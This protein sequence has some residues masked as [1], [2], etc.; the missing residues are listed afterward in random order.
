MEA[1]VPQDRI[2]RSA[3]TAQ[4]RGDFAMVSRKS[5]EMHDQL[6]TARLQLKKYEPAPWFTT[7]RVVNTE[8][9][10]PSEWWSKQFQTQAS[11]YGTPFI[12]LVESLGDGLKGYNPLA[13]NTDFFAAALGGDE[14]MGHKVVYIESECQ[15]YFYDCRDRIYKPTSEAKLGNLI[16]AL[17]IRCAEELPNTC[18]KLNLFL[19]FRSDKTIRDIIHR[20]KSIVTAD[21]NFFSSESNHERQNGPELYARVARAFVEQVLE[22]QSGEV[23]TLND[24][25]LRFCEYLRRKNMQPVKRRAF[26]DLV[27]PVIQDEFD[28]RVRND[29]RDEARNEWHCGWKGIRALDLEPAGQEN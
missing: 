22:R 24:A 3:Q 23:L 2:G 14:K 17:M 1:S 5:E 29:L 11:I 28:I 6:S 19:D 15:F 16:R 7:D 8:P 18:H 12:E 20:G 25:Y 21:D 13:I 26:K 27:P 10:T 4:R 9:T